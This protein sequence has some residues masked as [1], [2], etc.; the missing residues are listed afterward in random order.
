MFKTM[1]E[2]GAIVL[3]ELSQ[4]ANK[5]DGFMWDDDYASQRLNRMSQV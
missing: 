4:M 3:M 2:R 5:E 1:E